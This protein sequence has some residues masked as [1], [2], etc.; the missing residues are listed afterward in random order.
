[1][2]Q[3]NRLAKQVLPRLKLAP[4]IGI[5]RVW[6]VRLWSVTSLSCRLRILALPAP[7]TEIFHLQKLVDTPA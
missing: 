5:V 4:F 6:P 1:M 3:N 2:N 7:E